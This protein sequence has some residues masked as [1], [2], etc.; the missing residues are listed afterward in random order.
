[1]SIEV[2]SIHSQCEKTKRYKT[3][4]ISNTSS[5]IETKSFERAIS[6]ETHLEKLEREAK[7]K[8]LADLQEE[9]ARKV[10]NSE[11][12]MEMS[13]TSNGCGSSFRR[14]SPVL[15]PDD[16]LTKISVW[17]DKTEAAEN[18]VQPFKVASVHRD[19]RCQNQ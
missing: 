15:L 17:M 1:M 8:E 7:Q 12:E 18:L 13:K 9:L 19:N 11:K 4:V 10:R 2:M 6:T 5:A 14:F 3:S 16:T